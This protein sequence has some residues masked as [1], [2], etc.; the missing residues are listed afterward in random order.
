MKIVIE[1]ERLRIRELELSDAI[2]LSKVLCDRES[3]K[4]YPREK[5]SEEVNAWIGRNIERYSKHG[6]G[7]WAVERK[8]DNEF[9]GECGITLQN[10]DNEELPEVGYHTIRAYCNKGYASE[11]AKACLR[12][13]FRKFGFSAIYSYCNSAN[14]P[15]RRVME[16]IGMEKIKE[17]V[18]DGVCTVVYRTEIGRMAPLEPG[19]RE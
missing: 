11:A 3:M 12:F 16:K 6:F 8:S 2:A 10:I 9:L 15:S 5:T 14:I 13:G 1:T 18:G 7:L 4:Y 17:Y 19:E